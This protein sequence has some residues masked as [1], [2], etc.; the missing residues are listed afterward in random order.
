MFQLCKEQTALL[1]DMKEEK[2]DM[3]TN[4]NNFIDRVWPV[5]RPRTAM[6][7]RW[8]KPVKKDSLEIQLDEFEADLY[9]EK[10]KWLQENHM[11]VEEVKDF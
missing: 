7:S 10:P 3:I 11:V 8:A 2:V 6:V 1:Q 4:A 5:E 9:A